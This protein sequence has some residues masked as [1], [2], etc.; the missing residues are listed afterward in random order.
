MSTSTTGSTTST[1]IAII[2]SGFGGLGAAIKLKDAGEH[3]LVILER[4]HDLGGTWRDNTYPGCRCDVQSNLYSFSFA[5]NP[6]WSQTYPSQPEIFDY[7][8]R[9]AADAGLGPHLRFGFDV[10]DVRFSEA[11]GRWRVTSTRGEE[12]IADVV[13]LATG[14]LAEPKLASIDGIDS[15]SGPLLHSASWDHSVDLKGKRV[16]VIG[17][18][19]SAIQ[20]IPSIA[21][22]VEH[23]TVFQRTPAWVLPHPGKVVTRRAKALYARVPAAQRIA[24][25]ADYWLREWLVVPFVKRPALMAGAERKA[26]EHLE[27]QVDDPTLRAAL[28][29]NYRLGC[30]RVLISDDYYP[31]IAAD[32]T[33][34]ETSAI[35]KVTTTGVL[36]EDGREVPLDVLISATGFHVT[37]NPMAAKVHGRGDATLSHAYQGTLPSYLGTSFPG[38]PNLFMVTGPNT[39]LGHSSMVF[40]I[41]SQLNYISEAI[42]VID[43]DGASLVEPSLRAASSYDAKISAKLPSTIWGSGCA[44]WYLN[45]QGRNVTI[46]PDFT[47]TYRSQTRHFVRD[48][49]VLSLGRGGPPEQ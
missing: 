34:L 24:R 17:T 22:D 5:L 25:W 12:L 23:L 13:I 26:L 21:N 2:G 42:Q 27:A 47:F 46:W 40:M 1:R 48:D 38:F 33:T 18:G 15:F 11:T 35:S 9:V 14:G 32:S 10:A 6:T 41:E 20:I 4:A 3:D 28:T 16:G 7:L 45:D 43:R 31:A 37:D 30:K 36:L 39:A 49:H 8:K 44:S 19:A 29:P